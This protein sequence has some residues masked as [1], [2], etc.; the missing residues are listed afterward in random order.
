MTEISLIPMAVATIAREGF[1]TM[2]AR[3]SEIFASI[4][5]SPGHPDLI[6]AVNLL[7]Q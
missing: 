3:A 6:A 1:P 2:D 5:F 4:L 7:M